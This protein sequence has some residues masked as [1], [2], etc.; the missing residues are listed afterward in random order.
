MFARL[1]KCEIRKRRIRPEFNYRVYIIIKVPSNGCV[2]SDSRIMISEQSDW[3]VYNLQTKYTDITRMRGSLGWLSA[4]ARNYTTADHYSIAPT[5]SPRACSISRCGLVQL[6]MCLLSY[7]A[8]FDFAFV[9]SPLCCTV[10]HC[11]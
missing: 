6:Y 9:Y 7:H 5:Y 2:R 11:A 8:H 4:H 3:S 1:P 10:V